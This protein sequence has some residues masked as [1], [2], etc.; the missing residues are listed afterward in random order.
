MPTENGPVYFLGVKPNTNYPQYFKKA[1]GK[2]KGKWSQ[3]SAII[4]PDADAIANVEGLDGMSVAS[5]TNSAKGFDVAFGEWE[6]VDED[7]MA[8]VIDNAVAEGKDKN[9]PAKIQHMNVV[10]NIKGQVVRSSS[11][12][13][14][15]LPK[16]LY[17]VNGKKYMV[18]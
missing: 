5:G 17:I 12:S 14:E 11:S 15:G 3:Y 6:I 7:Q 18:K 13:V 1:K 2:G 8:T 4:V 10:Y 16:G 9:E